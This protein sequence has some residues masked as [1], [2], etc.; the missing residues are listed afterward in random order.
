MGAGRRRPDARQRACSA[1]RARCTGAERV[2]DP[3]C[4]VSARRQDRRTEI[5]VAQGGGRRVVRVTLAPRSGEVRVGLR[6]RCGHPRCDGCGLQPAA[7]DGVAPRFARVERRAARRGRPQLLEQFLTQRSALC[8]IERPRLAGTAATDACQRPTGGE[9]EALP[10]AV[11]TVEVR[12]GG[13][14]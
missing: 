5:G 9:G 6:R 3:C 7:R 8:C 11:I 4:G 12:I 13:G 2:G 10:Q 1:R 14:R